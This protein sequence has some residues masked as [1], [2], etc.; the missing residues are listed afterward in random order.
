MAMADRKAAVAK[1]SGGGTVSKF[2][3]DVRVELTKVIWPGRG[4]VTS[5]TL[6]VIV[7]VLFFAVFI[8]VLDL[9]FVNLIKII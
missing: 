7:A 6:V 4:E 9:I 1:T 8:G 3:R 5:S 2:F